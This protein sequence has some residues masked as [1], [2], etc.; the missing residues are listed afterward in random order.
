M[1]MSS[2]LREDELR[3]LKSEEHEDRMYKQ[4]ACL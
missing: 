3:D 1:Q 2:A 4:V